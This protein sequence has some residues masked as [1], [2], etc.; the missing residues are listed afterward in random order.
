[1]A[2]GRKAQGHDV[3]IQA[4]GKLYSESVSM[5][6]V[7]EKK[8]DDAQTQLDATIA[9]I[10]AKV[11]SLQTLRKQAVEDKQRNENLKIKLK[12]FTSG[13]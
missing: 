5:F 11:E 3:V 1:M 7:A 13:D 12:E 6:T 2:L 4:A 8:I 9:D 10:D